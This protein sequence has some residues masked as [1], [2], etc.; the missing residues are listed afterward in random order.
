MSTLYAGPGKLFVGTTALWP[1]GENG[2]IIASVEQA[3]EEYASAFYGRHGEQQ[4]DAL[5]RIKVTPFD[6]WGALGVLFPATLGCK[7]GAAAAALAAGTQSPP[8][9]L[10]PVKIWTPTG[11]LYTF[12][13]GGLVKPP[14]L[15]LG[16]GKALFGEAE[17]L[18]LGDLAKAL[19]AAAFLYTITETGAADP[20][21][22]MTMSDFIRGKWTGVWGDAAGFGGAEGDDPMEAE[23]EWVIT[24][25]VKWQPY[26]V[27]KLTRANLLVSV[28]FM[29]KA[30]LFGP[31]HTEIDAAIGINA[32]RTLGS[33]F[34]ESGEDLVLTGPG[35]KTITLKNADVKGAGFEFGGTKLGTGE[36]G[37][38]N[39]MTFTGGVPDALIEF[40]A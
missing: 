36:V 29:A 13:R 6:N 30:R 21:G 37:F 27:Q 7:V 1:E 17:F 35:G 39:E 15:H 33:R 28:G 14:E 4:A 8:A 19:G 5:A 40:S 23:E 10:T 12:V 38:V 31:T 24:P 16:V 22:L 3:S 25:S 18:C 11:R 26:T 20:G 9:A 2:Q 34:A 32:G